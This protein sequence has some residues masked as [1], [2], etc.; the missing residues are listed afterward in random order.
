MDTLKKNR[1]LVK[2]AT[3]IL[4]ALA[5][6]KL[7]IQ[8]FG[9]I[10]YGF[11]RDELLHL[12]VSEH[13]DFG[14]MEFPPCIAI[15][16]KLSFI[17][18]DYSLFGMRLLPTVA[19]VLILVMCCLMAKE[20][21]GKWRSVLFAGTCVLAF[22]PFYRNH[23]L[24]QP[25]AFDQL[26]W[27]A[28]FYFLICF[29]NSNDKKHL[30]LTG[31]ALG[32]GLQ[33]KYTMLVWAFG[34]VIGLIFYKRGELFRSRWL[35]FSA[36]LALLA[37]L[38]N[39]IWQY[40]HDFP[41]L[42]HAQ[43]L[44]QYQLSEN[45]YGDFLL[46]Q[47]I[48]PATFI[49]SILG[50]WWL[51]RNDNFRWIA[52]SV[53]VIFFTMLLTKSKS[54]YVFSIYPVLFAAG[55]VQLEAWLSKIK[56]FW[57]HIVAASI[58]FPFGPWIPEATPI[59]SVE[60]FVEYQGLEEKDGRIEL[61]SDYADMFGWH[62]Q[63]ALVDS[64]YRS[65]SSKEKNNCMIWAENYGEAGAI[66]ILGKKYGLPN[67]I[68]RHGSFWLWGYGNRDADVWISIGNEK[69]SVEQVFD[70]VEL[71]KIIH[72]RYAI[73]EENGI[74]LYICRKPKVDIEKWWSDYADHVFR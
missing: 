57:A 29:I 41:L 35:Y 1:P 64:V 56:P 65:L 69:P 55:G 24:F 71:V 47:I 23:T 36:I 53:L 33:N 60:K 9:N 13:L 42:K 44:S 15:L 18:F 19:G 39:L 54:Y 62:E 12:S 61:T 34:I 73:D 22:L 59:L 52:V 17:L 27:T 5:A 31:L 72:H 11:H 14:Y 6:L 2:K 7:V 48:L 50:L 10:N 49:T 46:D 28:G 63:V 25:V 20:L 45:G 43:A 67:P 74:P 26:F 4:I 66:K 68:S 40:L 32:L 37:F 3:V 58:F 38:P 16:G 70:E 51:I 8:F 21:G 30:L